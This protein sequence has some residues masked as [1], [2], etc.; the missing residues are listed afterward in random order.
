MSSTFGDKLEACVVLVCLIM[1]VIFL[2]MYF[3]KIL[4]RVLCKLNLRILP[5][6]EDTQEIEIPR[7]TFQV[8]GY[9]ETEIQNAIH[10]EAHKNNEIVTPP[11]II[12]VDIIEMLGHGEETMPI[13]IIV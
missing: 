3:Y 4:L 10:V 11:L 12:N 9:L 8:D 1:T 6:L 13:A 2:T 5:T 7:V